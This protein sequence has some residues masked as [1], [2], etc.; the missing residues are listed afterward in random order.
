MRTLGLKQSLVVAAGLFVTH[1]AM[2]DMGRTAGSWSASPSG[3]FTYS[4]PIWTPPGP[5]GMQ[6][7]LAFVYSS[8]AGNGTMGVGWSLA[9]F[10]S[11]DRCPWT[12]AEDGEDR[13]VKVD[14]TDRF[15]LDGNKL[16]ITSGSL[17]NYGSI[18]AVYQTQ[19]ADFSRVTSVNSAGTGPQHFIVHTKSGLI[20]EYGN[21]DDSR[22]V[23]SGTT[24]YRWMLNKVSDRE[25]NSYAITYTTS[26]S[27]GR[28]PLTVSWSPITA[29]A[30]V[31]QYS[32]SFN[33]TTKMQP[34]DF[35]EARQGPD[36]ITT[37]QRLDSVTIGYSA[38]GSSFSTKRQYVL[39]YE[40]SPATAQS[41]LT[42]V[43]ECA[44][45]TS[46]C[47]KP[48]I[49][50]YQD[51]AEGVSSSS[52]T[53][54]SAAS[55]TLA[56]K[57][58]FNGDGRTDIAYMSGSTW[59][60][61]FS[62]GSGFGAGVD[63]GIASTPKAGRF[64]ASGQDGFLVNIAG[65]WNYVGYS[66]GS[67]TTTST[68]AP[69]A[70]DT[71][72]TDYNGDGLEDL[73]WATVTSGGGSWTG[74][75]NLRL[76]TASGTAQIPS[77]SST[78][79]APLVT[80][81]G[82]FGGNFVIVPYTYC[83]MERHCDINGD[84]ASDLTVLLV[85]THNCSG[86]PGGCTP[87]QS[88]ADMVT[89][90]S[91]YFL[92]NSTQYSV[93]PYLGLRFNDD[94]CTDSIKFGSTSM[95]I[96]GCG[97]GSATALTLPA[98]PVGVLDWDGDGRTDI[99]V[100]NGGVLGV[101][102]SNGSLTT[103]F[104]NLLGTSIPY[105]SA[106]TYLAAD[107]EGDG[108]D[109]LVCFTSSSMSYYSHN[110]NG[111]VGL[112]NGTSVFA[113]QVPDLVSSI[114][115]GYGLSIG[116]R[117]VSTAQSNYTKGENTALPLVDDTN[118]LVILGRVRISD[119]ISVTYDLDY[120]YKGARRHGKLGA[121]SSPGFS[122][123]GSDD[124][125]LFG[126]AGQSAGFEWITVTDS[127][128]TTRQKTTYDQLF[129]RTGM[130]KKHESLQSSF[131][132]IS[133]STI[134]N[135]FESLDSSTNN[136]RYFPYV[137]KIETDWHEVGGARD[138]DLISNS[139]RTFGF[140]T[141][142]YGN[143]A[144]D[145]IVI[146]DED[147]ESD[148][149]LSG[150]SWTTA[151]T[152]TYDTALTNGADW[153]VGF[154]T[155]TQ[156]ASSSSVSTAP[157]V[158]RT[159]AATRDTSAP[160]KCRTK[161]VTVEPSSD[162]YKVVETYGFD[163]FGNV[164]A[165]DVVGV[166]PVSGGGFA[167]MPTRSTIVDWGTTGQFPI[168]VTDPSG[169]ITRFDYNY[170]LATMKETFD[171]NSTTSN[172]IKVQFSYDDF[173]RK[174]RETRPDLTY[175]T[176][177]YEDCQNAGGCV[178]AN[179]KMSIKQTEFDN[180]NAVIS[181]SFVYNDVLDQTLVTRSRLLNGATSWDGSYQWVER[182]YDAYGRA[183]KEYMPCATAAVSTS[184]R[185]STVTNTFD[186]LGRLT[187]ASR[188]QTQAQQAPQ[189]TDYFYEGRTQRLVDAQG[190]QTAR[191]LN[192]DS[193]VRQVR[194]ANNYRINFSYDAAGSL[195]GAVDSN[196]HTRL[197][198]VTVQYGVQPFQ[199]QG[200]DSALGHYTRTYNSLGELIGWTDA[201]NQAF[202]A[203]YDKLSRPLETRLEPSGTMRT[204]WAWGNVVGD[205]NRGR[206]RYVESVYNG[207]TYSET[208]TYDHRTRI[209]T[210]AIS[211]PN[212][213]TFNYEYAY[214]AQKGWLDVLTYPVSTQS[215]RLAVKHHYQ[216]G[217][218]K[219]VSDANAPSTV[220][221]TANSSN[222]WGQI[223]QEILGNGITTTRVFDAVTSWLSSI[224][225]GPSANTTQIQNLTF[226]YDLVGN[227]AQR[228]K[229]GLT[230]TFFYGSGTDNLYRLKESTLDSGTTPF[231]NLELTYDSSGSIKTKNEVGL[232]DQLVN[233]S[234]TWTPDNY[235]LEI[236]VA[237]HIATFAYGPDK[238]R[239]KM[240]FYNGSTTQATHYIG[241]LLEKIDVGSSVD[242]KHT[243]IGGNGVVA[244]YTR[245]NAGSPTLQ[246]VLGDH[247]GST[248]SFVENGSGAVT[249][250]SFGAYGMR[251]DAATWLGEPANRAALDAITRQGYTYQTVLGT[252][253]LNHMNGRVQD[254]AN[255]RFLSADPFVPHPHDTQSFNRYSYV[256]NN[257][258]TYVDPS[259]FSDTYCHIVTVPFGTTPTGNVKHIRG[260]EWEVCG[261]I[262]IQIVH[263]PDYSGL[264]G[265]ILL[266]SISS[267]R[268]VTS[269]ASVG[270]GTGSTDG[271]EEDPDCLE[272]ISGGDSFISNYA[273]RVG[274][275]A[276]QILDSVTLGTDFGAAASASVSVFGLKGKLEAGFYSFSVS[277]TLAGDL[278]TTVKSP[279]PG[280]L[281][282]AE[283]SF[284]TGPVKWGAARG[285][286]TEGM[287]YRSGP[288]R[289]VEDGFSWM[290]KV[291]GWS[292]EVGKL[293]AHIQPGA[294]IKLEVDV[295]KAVRAVGCA[296]TT[297]RE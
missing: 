251:R 235:P 24:A 81:L 237:G 182:Q 184:C 136:Q 244:I 122:E 33:Y 43:K 212:Q 229:P 105:N 19:I 164:S 223:T 130:P 113:T 59:R 92:T 225:S 178:Y 256:R 157:S 288:I 125:L 221:W 245:S 31:Y 173:G 218:L 202:S 179:H 208:Y 38:S 67:F 114:A 169:A 214:D 66:G 88:G 99:V 142:T 55:S 51:G 140:T 144:T 170:D 62:T 36:A 293:G 116:P 73:V 111:S 247:Q 72:L 58:D 119:G 115:D 104:S 68:G 120:T 129:P 32:A 249:N 53:G 203:S 175:T 163:N 155:Q 191:V 250:A 133:V 83:P 75:A 176:W 197:S 267:L 118:A 74:T 233:Q 23:L 210:K 204:T 124:D 268:S 168:S 196:S 42:E 192:V 106:C 291:K 160:S 41:R 22:V 242:F 255:G 171:P 228:Q 82:S 70:A 135:L 86:G 246:Y 264:N 35:L 189:W 126:A 146:T 273:A 232:P 287:S 292:R 274:N 71:V 20:M 84:G 60:V 253:G 97:N 5:K 17:A 7:S 95:R 12:I 145:T 40:S 211:I 91:G 193:T 100:N 271:A 34:K 154:V 37:R 285:S 39:T 272:P 266:N 8:Q 195:L 121:T 254:A 147:S 117:Y 94:I 26:N 234:I 128:N 112:P 252:M 131:T 76:N 183:F 283:A 258:P 103:P 56:G 48:T 87:V 280:K 180:A 152:Y 132:P 289:K 194:D 3:A 297:R 1:A 151:T 107:V 139:E 149:N 216:N 277:T 257:P 265:Q 98:L 217:A 185:S 77:Y 187:K 276:F 9:G 207:V 25:G 138:G 47:L 205:F 45:S 239:W 50:D 156:V 167:N 14:G 150:E 231:K 161:T 52:A 172:V 186:L 241:G 49:I 159:T 127:R 243:I 286:I 284:A 57:Y 29:G 279:L 46:N 80:G 269:M 13:A 10:S 206:L 158:T 295:G 162:R 108:L 188:P 64:V 141:F 2:A 260:D 177:S 101:Y 78:V 263:R 11:I 219:A 296:L 79:Y 90:G 222:A 236:N 201:K 69:V 27:V 270:G 18:G 143:V 199:V 275:L 278:R 259:G 213:G 220:F 181:D 15:C 63:T 174:T 54:V 224:Q 261:P 61:A 282:Y 110:G 238:Q 153:C 134:Q 93:T 21:T 96:H 123:N 190:K 248:E 148:P 28:V 85:T 215:Y 262:T 4:I 44:A 166:Q 6:P 137:W 198:G 290:A 89:G 200:T 240:S 209:Q 294:G 227:V 281:S 230:E 165:T 102:K 16:R 226:A 30:S 65:T 109:E